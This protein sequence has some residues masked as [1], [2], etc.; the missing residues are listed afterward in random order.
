[1]GKKNKK[2]KMSSED[3]KSEFVS[4]AKLSEQA[5]RYDDMAEYMRQVTESGIELTNE[6]RNLLSV[7]YKNVVGSRRSSWRVIS[8]IEAK[9]DDGDKKKA[10]ALEYRSKVET[11]L[12]DICNVVLGL[13]DKHLIPKSTS[14]ESKVFYLKMK[15][16][17]YRYL[18]EVA[19][20]Q[21]RKD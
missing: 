2:R 11:E 18:A 15:G 21:E 5:E 14:G 8:S 9:C 16:D 4:R 7:A 20:G 6:E 1:M 10:Y 13:L 12:Q 19:I 3:Q 17:Y